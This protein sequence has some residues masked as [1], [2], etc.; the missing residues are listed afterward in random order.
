MKILIAIHNQIYSEYLAFRLNKYDHDIILVNNGLAAINALRD[1]LFDVV[2]LG[3]T[4]EFFN[5]LEVIRLFREHQVSDLVQ[6]GE[7]PHYNPHIVIATR[8]RNEKT[9]KNAADML[10]TDYLY[11]PIQTEIL[12][13]TILRP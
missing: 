6:C 7:K 1:N 13:N 9:I 8:I 5:G 2:V 3:I 4:L 11:I 12:I 10:V